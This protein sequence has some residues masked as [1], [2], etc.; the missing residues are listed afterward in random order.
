[1]KDYTEVFENI[2]KANNKFEEEVERGNIYVP[3]AI[4][5]DKKL[6]SNDAI[7]LSAYYCFNKNIK[8]ADEFIK[9]DA[10]QLNKIKK[11]L[12][13]LGYIKKKDKTAEQLKT[14]TIIEQFSTGNKVCEWCGRESYVLQQHHFPIPASQ[15]GINTVDICPNCHYTFHKLESEV[16]E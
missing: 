15:G 4:S 7:Y 3:F 9:K 6:T 13:T 2:K 10:N 8:K 5:S 11:H 14:Q 16:Y 1:M 12:A